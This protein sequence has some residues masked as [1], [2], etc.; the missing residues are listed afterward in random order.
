MF[1]KLILMLFLFLS[2][3]GFAQQTLT[4]SGIVKD[5]TGLAVPGAKVTMLMAND[6]LSVSTGTN[7][8]FSFTKVQQAPFSITISALGYLPNRKAYKGVTKTGAFFL[9]TTVL[10]NS[11]TLLN[12][13]NIVG[14]NPIKL[15]EDTVEFNAAA[16]KVQDG[17]PVEDI[18]KKL[19]GVDVDKDGNV[20][21]Q[22][23]SVTKVRVN[24]KDFFNGDVKTA[25]QNLPASIVQS[26]QIIDDY[27]DQANLTGLKTGESDKILNITI[28][29]DKNYGYF[30]QL[31]L[32]DGADAQS[33]VLDKNESNRYVASGNLFKFNGDQQIAI[34]ANLNNTN[35][36]LFSFGGGGPRGGG[37]GGGGG[38]PSGN[39]ASSNGITATRSAGLNY[40]DQWGKNISV[41]GS[42]SFSDNTV[43]TLSST[44]QSNSSLNLPSINNYSSNQTDGKQNHRFNL[45]IEYKIDPLNYL[46]VSPTFSYAGVNTSLVQNSTLTNNNTVASDYIL[47]STLNSSSPNYGANVLYNHKFNT[48]G[49]NFSVNFSAGSTS[50]TQT[51]NPVYSYLAGVANAPV[52]QLISTDV[53]L[54]SV[55]ASLSYM[56]PLSKR[57]FLELNYA[58]HYAHTT[59]D[60]ATDTLTTANTRNRYN[61]LSNDYAFDF[62]TNRVGLNY[63]FIEQKYNY[64]L[65][66]ALQPVLLSGYSAK[67][68]ADTRVSTL[69][70]APNARFVYNVSRSQSLNFNYSGASN[71]PIYTELQP[72]TDFSN[73][74]YPVQ[75]NPDL[76]PEF[77]NNLSLRYNKFDF[78]SGNVLFAGLSFTQTNNKIA[79]NTITYP[80]SYTP[81]SKLAGTILTR[82]QNADGYY[83]AAGN[84]VY[85]RPWQERRYTLMFNGNISYSN[86]IS[87]VSNVAPVTYEQTTE[88]NIAKSI[89]LTQGVKFRTS[90]DNIIDAELST[91]YGVTSTNNSLKQNNLNNNFRTLNLGLNGKNYFYKT[92][93]LSYDFTKTL[94]Y[95]YT[96]ATNPNILN[97][98]VEKKFLKL[99]A[100]ALRLSA[101]DLFNQNTGFSTTQNG[102]YIT[103]TESNRLGRYFLLTFTL[104]LQK[105]AGQKPGL[106]N[107]A[108]R[109]GNPPMGG[110]PLGGP[111]MGDY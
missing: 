97:A 18:L 57:S 81:D 15:K 79:A 70:F 98:Y 106:P 64:T 44:I 94:Y 28:R 103:Q 49:R 24:G 80:Q 54:D 82:Y 56:E 42:Y 63:R 51:Q 55:G 40:R 39:A 4:V 53:K 16:Y 14:V 59:S 102:S 76:K 101:F 36:N 86:N 19:P 108:P 74:L 48:S 27:G 6:S 13:V 25:T 100:G 7:G 105:F 11:S 22:G 21:A 67:A 47:N 23:K 93:T 87:Y 65:G 20:T 69:N 1:R 77:N 72:V 68:G 110:P 37:P 38:G 111:P 50:L 104:R 52:N 46:K 62:I 31:N 58:Y 99:N 71:Q 9:G 32:G 35:A 3:Q 90:I 2:S 12:A 107:G 89:N 41:Y 33:G 92:W 17:A 83:S 78:M 60:K 85:A 75:G 30:G 88:K 95:G 61:L 84:Y 91:S 29:P 109:D 10:K 8:V 96:G 26:I 34:L 73:S 66:V 5:S 45:N 43:N